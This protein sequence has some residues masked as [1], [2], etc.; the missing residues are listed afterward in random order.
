MGAYE[1]AALDRTGRES[2][3]VMEG[4]TP[5]QVR[6]I[7]RE[8]GL[9]PIQ[10]D[11]IARNNKAGDATGGGGA[12]R[13]SSWRSISANDL[14][15][16]T[17]QL[18]TLVRAALPIEEAL[19]AVSQQTTRPRIKS[20]LI[21]VRSRV[22][23][24]HT[25]ASGLAQFPRVFPELYRATVAA[26]EQAGQLEN[27]LERLADYT[28]NRQEMRNQMMLATI[29]P[30]L[31]LLVSLGI[32]LFLVTYIMPQVVDVFDTRDQQLPL[33][34]T[35]LIGLSEFLRSWWWLLT[36]VLVGGTTALVLW[37]RQ[38]GPRRRF[39][40]LLLRL[41][42]V[43]RLTAGFNAARFART[44]SILNG[45]GVPVLEAMRI[46]GQ[47]V[48]NIPMREAVEVASRK[49]REGGNISRALGASKLFP[50]M[51][52]HLIA[53]GESSGRLDEMLERAAQNQESEVTSLVQG[54]TAAMQPLVILIMG[55]I[56]MIIVAAILLPI[57]QLNQLLG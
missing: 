47:V 7:L 54:M 18:A 8:Q 46:A 23:E 25:L 24:G 34:T 11:E 1:Y 35:A 36:L 52:I 41:P 9:I 29:Y 20:I 53:S 26:G 43:G 28:E 39:H 42:L 19:L 33:L 27:V 48:V 6:Q 37:L 2:K 17:R 16:V 30:A 22:M 40:N 49:V 38:P 57:F 14:A 10:V 56:V 13:G 5:R 4:D 45:S 44:L 51:T 55:G 50:P 12:L 21:A 31:L 3:G 32:A 15:L